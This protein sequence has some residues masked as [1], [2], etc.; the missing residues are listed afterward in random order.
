MA[1]VGRPAFNP[2]P[3]LAFDPLD[4]KAR[5]TWAD[6]TPPA[7]RRPVLQRLYKRVFTDAD[8]PPEDSPEHEHFRVKNPAGLDGLRKWLDTELGQLQ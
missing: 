2:I 7:A 3:K 6:H 1:G 5:R 8:M 4:E